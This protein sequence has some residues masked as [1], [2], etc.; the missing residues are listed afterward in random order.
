VRRSS[1]AQVTTVAMATAAALLTTAPAAAAPPPAATPQAAAGTVRDLPAELRERLRDGLPAAPSR[2]ALG[3][4]VTVY[5][6]DG[7]VVVYSLRGTV[8]VLQTEQR[9]A[10]TT[11]VTVSSDVLFAFGS[12]ALDERART[13]VAAVA[14]DLPQGAAVQVV[15]HTDGVGEDASNQA[16]SER[17]ARA[18]AAALAQGRPDLVPAPTGR[19]ET[20][21][22]EREGGADDDAARA[23][24]RRVVISYAG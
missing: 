8:E 14:A 3:R 10:G 11:S 17:R 18:V 9:S 20:E 12:D 16:L 22:L 19:G 23:A 21:P 2:A 24:N 7:R 13:A 4:S 6:P 15:G 1:R 5:D